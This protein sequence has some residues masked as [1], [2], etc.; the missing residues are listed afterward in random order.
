MVGVIW[1]LLC[2]DKD[3]FS[4]SFGKVSE[5][6]SASPHRGS[7]PS[8]AHTG[9]DGDWGLDEVLG[10][11]FSAVFTVAQPSTSLGNLHVAAAGAGRSKGED[12]E[13][14]F[15]PSSPTPGACAEPLPQPSRSP[16]PYKA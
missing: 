10:G 3:A 16:V 11:D 15:E 6:T 4:S 14:P 13:C 12:D 9:G 5:H 8:A 7:E 1:V 2:C